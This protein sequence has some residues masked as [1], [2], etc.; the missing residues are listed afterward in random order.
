MVADLNETLFADRVRL[1]QRLNRVRGQD[2]ALAV[3]K[4]VQQIRLSKDKARNRQDRLPQPSFSDDLPIANKRADIQAAIAANQV[5]IVCGETGSGKTTQLPKICLAL[6]RG[7]FG[8][9]GCT[10][11]RRIAARSV[12]AR[13]AQELQTEVGQ[14]V[15]YKVR[16][17][18][19]VQENTLIKVM[20]DGILLA[21]IHS[22][23]WLSQYD[24][25][26]IDFPS[27]VQ[28][29]GLFL[30]G[31]KTSVDLNT[32]TSRIL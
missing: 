8:T 1:G 15:G 25:I 9:I 19:R 10:Q 2:D 27:T 23:R 31:H 16:F 32:S 14:L 5:V 11:P 20:T 6:K 7:I 29:A 12:A 18:D 3:E 17:T 22:D 21:E 26:I 13:I 24:T 30:G 28:V 4:L